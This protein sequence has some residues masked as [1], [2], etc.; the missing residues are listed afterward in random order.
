MSRQ[1]DTMRE[2]RSFFDQMRRR[3]EIKE[4]PPKIENRS[5][6]AKESPEPSAKTVI[7]VEFGDERKRL[8]KH[9]PVIHLFC[10]LCNVVPVVHLFDSFVDFDRVHG[11]DLWDRCGDRI[12][13]IWTTKIDHKA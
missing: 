5:N 2:I 13:Q 1:K 11:F 7:V 10:S 8:L 6:T 3:N 12:A 4:T 9:D